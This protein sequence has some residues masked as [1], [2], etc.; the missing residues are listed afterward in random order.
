MKSKELDRGSS[1]IAFNV[2]FHG[3]ERL[4]NLILIIFRN[5]DFINSF[6][7]FSYDVLSECA[8]GV[9]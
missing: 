9:L 2:E 1:L 5:H 7:D 3:Y 8:F 4:Q 6:L